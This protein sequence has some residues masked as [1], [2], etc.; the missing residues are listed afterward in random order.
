MSYGMPM[1]G[2]VDREA[3]GAGSFTFDD[4]QE[5][6]VEAMLTCWRHPDRE[7]G[8]QRLRAHWPDIQREILAGDYDARGG[9]EA[10]DVTIRPASLTRLETAEME[11]A[12]GWLDHVSPADR[13]LVGLAITALASGQRE[14]SWRRLLRP[15]GLTKG[16]DGL[17]MRYGRAIAAIAGRLNGG[18][19]RGIVVNPNNVTR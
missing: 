14:V 11:E 4:V 9:L 7:R 10:G 6:L 8:W 5:R 13:K 18:N 3:S 1:G 12:F 2:R 16:S 19:A 17:R 15:M